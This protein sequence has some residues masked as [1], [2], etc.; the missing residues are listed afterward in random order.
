MSCAAGPVAAL[1]AGAAS[2]AGPVSATASGS[3][4]VAAGSL[5][6]GAGA[7]MR[8]ALVPDQPN[9]LTPATGAALVS[10]NGISRV[11]GWT[12]ALAD[13]ASAGPARLMLGGIV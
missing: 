9:E 7:R 13:T 2:R 12:A 3:S 8:W 1:A 6:A 5:A 11:A 4:A 10:G